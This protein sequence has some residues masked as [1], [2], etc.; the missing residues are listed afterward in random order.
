[1]LVPSQM[2]KKT[3]NTFENTY[4]E[5]GTGLQHGASPVVSFSRIFSNTRSTWQCLLFVLFWIYF[6]NAM[7]QAR[8]YSL[9]FFKKSDGLFFYSCKL[10][11]FSSNWSINSPRETALD[12]ILDVSENPHGNVYS[13]VLSKVVAYQHGVY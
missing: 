3:T 4:N 7:C 6:L 2:L 8:I 12:I 13:K 5:C 10:I 9:C 11:T 1:M